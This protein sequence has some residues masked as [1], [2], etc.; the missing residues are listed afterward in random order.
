MRQGVAAKPSDA[1]CCDDAL[2]SLAALVAFRRGWAATYDQSDDDHDYYG[3][4]D[5]P[6]DEL[7]QAFQCSLKQVEAHIRPNVGYLPNSWILGD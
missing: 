5:E 3:P 2:D 7:C 1:D 4:F 6:I